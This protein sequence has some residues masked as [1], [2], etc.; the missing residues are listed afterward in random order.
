MWIVGRG[1]P[2][3]AAQVSYVVTGFGVVWSMLL[4]GES[5]SLWIWA[6]LAAIFTGLFLTQPRPGAP[7][8]YGDASLNLKTR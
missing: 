6:A 1:G 2:V 8:A 5:Y 4:L 7:T 3:F